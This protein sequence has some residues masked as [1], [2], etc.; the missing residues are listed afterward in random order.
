MRCIEREFSRKPS[1]GEEAEQRH[2][3]ELA[4]YEVHYYAIKS[5]YVYGQWISRLEMVQCVVT[6][7]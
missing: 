7:K 6:E 5:E 3:R 2:T 4:C 1:L